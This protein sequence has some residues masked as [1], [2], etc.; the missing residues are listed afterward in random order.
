MNRSEFLLQ[1]FTHLSKVTYIGFPEGGLAFNYDPETNRLEEEQYKSL[2]SFKKS[3]E[4]RYEYYYSY[5][6]KLIVDGTR[7]HE[8][9]VEMKSSAE[10]QS[11]EWAER[12][13]TIKE[14]GAIRQNSALVE[15]AILAF[16]KAISSESLFRHDNPLM[17]YWP[18]EKERY[19]LSYEILDS[20]RAVGIER[21][22]YGGSFFL[23]SPTVTYEGIWSWSPELCRND[24]EYYSDTKA[25]IK[26]FK[27]FLS[28][29]RE[30]FAAAAVIAG[31]T[32]E[33]SPIN[34]S[35]FE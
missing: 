13:F 30:K 33:M 25:D 26:K 11:R 17:F 20:L 29:V 31:L 12:F 34:D 7:L 18:W 32:I 28:Q 23:D 22:V 14:L 15:E 9:P 27:K 19:L 8:V 3:S 16:N 6:R 1:Q 24:M 10:E 5:S 21:K 4:K 35:C 2:E